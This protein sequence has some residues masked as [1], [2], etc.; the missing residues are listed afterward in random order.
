[1]LKHKI[2]QL[3]ICDVKK[4]FNFASVFRDEILNN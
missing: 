3:K 4:M 2:I 1:M